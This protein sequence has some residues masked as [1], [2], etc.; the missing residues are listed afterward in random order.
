MLLS[1]LPPT[2]LAK[3]QSWPEAP[4]YH[5][6]PASLQQHMA[7]EMHTS[8][9][10]A[11][12]LSRW[13]GFSSQRSKDNFH[14]IQAPAPMSTSSVLS[15]C[16]VG[17]WSTIHMMASPPAMLTPAH[18]SCELTASSAGIS[19]SYM[20]AWL[21][22]SLL[23]GLYS[24]ATFSVRPVSSLQCPLHFCTHLPMCTHDTS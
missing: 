11:L 1:T 2:H 3:P 24:N 21:A 5:A 13:L 9:L 17:E 18:R 8:M 15:P 23:T 10:T 7:R 22:S 19:F 20:S 12:T 14:Q 6:I 16:T 4:L